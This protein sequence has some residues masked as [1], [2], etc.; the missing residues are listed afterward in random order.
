MTII[1][2]LYVIIL[3]LLYYIYMLVLSVA[4]SIFSRGH[5]NIVCFSV[6]DGCIWP[7]CDTRQLHIWGKTINMWC[8]RNNTMTFWELCRGY[9]L[10]R[11]LHFRCFRCC[12]L[13]ISGLLNIFTD[14]RYGIWRRAICLKELTGRAFVFCLWCGNS[15]A[16]RL[17]RESFLIISGELFCLYF[18][19]VTQQTWIATLV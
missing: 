4:E 16:I 8:E 12:T 5:T 10:S 9:Q 19:F 3:F 17:R 11:S 1:M 18:Y 2:T 15:S 13:G 6:S 7:A 14:E